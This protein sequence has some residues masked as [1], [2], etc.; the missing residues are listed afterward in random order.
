MKKVPH[1]GSSGQPMDC[2]GSNDSSNKFSHPIKRKF[3]GESCL[4]DKFPRGNSIP[5]SIRYKKYGN[6]EVS[7]QRDHHRKDRL[8]QVIRERAPIE[9]GPKR[10]KVRGPSFLSLE[11]RLN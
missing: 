8:Q 9:I 7:R 10:L 1:E 11:S 4:K 6:E 5:I 3:D 2:S